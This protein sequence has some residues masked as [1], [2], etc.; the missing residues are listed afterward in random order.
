MSELGIFRG[1]AFYAPQVSPR[2]KELITSHGGRLAVFMAQA[3][4]ILVE[5]D[6]SL[7]RPLIWSTLMRKERYPPTQLHSSIWLCQKFEDKKPILRAEWLETCIVRGEILGANLCWGLWDV[8]FKV[9]DR[10]WPNTVSLALP[11]RA[12]CP[13]V[14]QNLRNQQFPVSRQ[15]F[16]PPPL[17]Q[18]IQSPQSRE[19]QR[20]A[21]SLLPPSIQ[22]DPLQP[23][24]ISRPE[25]KSDTPAEGT[26]IVTSIP[27]QSQN[28]GLP[29]SLWKAESLESSEIAQL[30]KP[31]NTPIVAESSR[32]SPSRMLIAIDGDPE[33][34][35]TIS[36]RLMVKK[37]G[38]VVTTHHLADTV[39]LFIAPG[40]SIVV[41]EWD[42]QKFAVSSDWLRRSHERGRWLQ[43]E[44]FQVW[45]K[46]YRLGRSLTPP[47]WTPQSPVFHVLDEGD[48]PVH[49]GR[50]K[51]ESIPPLRSEETISP[52]RGVFG[53]Q[54]AT[55]PKNPLP[56]VT[57]SHE[58]NGDS[59]TQHVSPHG[60]DDSVDLGISI[61]PTPAMDSSEAND[62][63]LTEDLV[64][65]EED[66][67]MDDDDDEEDDDES[68]ETD[69][70][71]SSSEQSESINR[72][73]SVIKEDKVEFD[74]LV[75]KLRDWLSKL[76]R[77]KEQGLERWEA[78]NKQLSYLR[79]QREG[80]TRCI[81][82]LFRKYRSQIL[83]RLPQLQTIDEEIVRPAKT[84][85]AQSKIATRRRILSEWEARVLKGSSRQFLPAEKQTLKRK[86]D[87]VHMNYSFKKKVIGVGEAKAIDK[88]SS[89]RPSTPVLKDAGHAL[90]SFV[91]D[92]KTK[93]IRKSDK[94]S[95]TS[96]S[97]QIDSDINW[98]ADKLSKLPQKPQNLKHWLRNLGNTPGGYVATSHYK[99]WKEEVM[100]ATNAKRQAAGRHVFF[101]DD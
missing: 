47:A 29:P 85:R 55:S 15:F 9:P 71:A 34:D 20:P 12:T 43:K 39:V 7:P 84:L 18:D 101:V 21:T 42:E 94:E 48:I 40:S 66:M 57:T 23:N 60:A 45:P 97:S 50:G 51:D 69:S 4:L 49:D 59:R 17:E 93:T 35:E 83:A 81:R 88:P 91:I 86:P 70:T 16:T 63:L 89:E 68:F 13:V 37:L 26:N 80:S 3:D 24:T 79:T 72:R 22:N 30:P 62:A 98:L 76:Q 8:H 99:R 11:R 31:M 10:T 73:H 61:T 67:E 28:L 95:K 5:L 56:T 90:P 46:M 44:D 92:S 41:G 19:I 74:W 65:S 36:L 53:D 6:R 14:P 1:L 96:P 52:S 64:S 25:K 82:S 2:T 33:D 54:P 75:V 78:L 32:T 87:A 27:E 58:P 100:K 77:E 38:G